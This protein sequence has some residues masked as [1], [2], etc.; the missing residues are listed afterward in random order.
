MGTNLKLI[1]NVA[2]K[3]VI[4][5]RKLPKIQWEDRNKKK[6]DIKYFRK[7]IEGHWCNEISSLA[8]KTLKERQWETTVQLP[9]T[10]DILLFQTYTHDLASNAYEKL[11]NQIEVRK[12][13]KILTECVLAHT[14]MF[15]KKRV[16]DV[17]YLKI[18]TY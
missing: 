14:V 6:S 16:G 4:E 12:N 13:Y 10:S 5:K 17:Q 9:L 7:L 2:F 15:N 1:C 18:E 3:I 8:L 11:K